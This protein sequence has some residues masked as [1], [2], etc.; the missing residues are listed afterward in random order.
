[1]PDYNTTVAQVERIPSA[2]DHLPSHHS[3]L[4]TSFIVAS[5][6]N[7]F[8]SHRGSSRS[9]EVPLT[10]EPISVVVEGV[11]ELGFTASP[12]ASPNMR[13]SEATRAESRQDTISPVGSLTRTLSV[14]LVSEPES[15]EPGIISREEG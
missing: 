4:K 11:A 12:P 5:A 1:M 15:I 8:K 2:S 10:Q 6:V 7:K 9:R 3:S 13:A 14:P